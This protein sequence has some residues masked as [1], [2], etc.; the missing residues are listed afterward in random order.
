[1]RSH[2]H[3]GQHVIRWHSQQLVHHHYDAAAGGFVVVVVLVVVVVVVVD[4]VVVGQQHVG[5]GFDTTCHHQPPA[6]AM[7]VAPPFRGAL[8][9]NDLEL[10]YME[11]LILS[12]IVE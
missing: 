6:E 11:I 2:K 12:L 3:P 4:D 9:R 1:M 10:Y 5:A 8:A 7:K